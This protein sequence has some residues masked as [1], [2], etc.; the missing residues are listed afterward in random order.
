MLRGCRITIKDLGKPNPKE[1]L[2]IA[3][4]NINGYVGRVNAGGISSCAMA[5]V[6]EH[7]GKSVK[8]VDVDAG[9]CP[10]V[11]VMMQQER[12]NQV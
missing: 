11:G 7:E 9:P 6:E 5:V 1:G 3:T 12:L 8:V 2:T 10:P 4:Q